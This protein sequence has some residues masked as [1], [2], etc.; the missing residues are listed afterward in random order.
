ML[1]C[2]CL[3]V[4]VEGLAGKT[5]ALRTQIV[6]RETLSAGHSLCIFYALVATN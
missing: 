2:A 6:T 1:G 4:G 5:S 3:T